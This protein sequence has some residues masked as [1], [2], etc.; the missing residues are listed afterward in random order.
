MD[1]C[2]EPTLEGREAWEYA[3]WLAGHTYYHDTWCAYVGALLELRELRIRWQVRQTLIT[4][5]K[6]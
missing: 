3:L 5:C 4:I 1:R 2:I 6:I